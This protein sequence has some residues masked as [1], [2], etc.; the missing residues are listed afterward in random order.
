M[1]PNVKGLVRSREFSADSWYQQGAWRLELGEV[2]LEKDTEMKSYCMV[3]P[4]ALLLAIAQQ[5]M[6]KTPDIYI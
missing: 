2:I 5:Y 6:L 3:G 4:I 1:T